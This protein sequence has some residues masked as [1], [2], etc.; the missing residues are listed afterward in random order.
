MGKSITRRNLKNGIFAFIDLLGFSDRVQRIKTDE[1]L[2]K[3]DDEVVFVQREFEHKSSDD[4]VRKSQRIVGKRVLAFSD[5]VVISV[6]L[7]SDLTKLQGTFDVLMSELTSFA[8]A[9]GD[10]VQRGIFLRGG[11]DLGYWFHRKDTLISPAMVNAYGLEHEACVPMIAITPALCKYLSKHSDR[12]YYNKDIEPFSKVFKLYRELPN[13]Q[14]HWFINYLRI[15]LESVEPVIVGEDRE[16]YLSADADGRDRMRTELWQSACYEW[17]LSHGQII[18]EAHAKA[19]VA[20]VR[21]KYEWLASYHNAEVKRFFG[22]RAKS[23][24]IEEI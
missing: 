22:R 11:V 6:P 1:D 13:G 14:T 23:L 10:C 5:C 18:A 8:I 2:R 15:C 16:R 20:S 19:T 3:L 12:G 24:L 21:L 7:H 9:Q 4:F 17:A